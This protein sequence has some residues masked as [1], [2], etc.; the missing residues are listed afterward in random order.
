MQAIRANCHN[1]LTPG[2]FIAQCHVEVVK[3]LLHAS[4]NLGAVPV[5][6]ALLSMAPP[7]S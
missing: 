5:V 3:V 7:L 1:L 2:R 4:F 6:E